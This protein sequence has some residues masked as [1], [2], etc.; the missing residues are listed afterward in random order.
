MTKDLTISIVTPSYNQGSF[1]ED[2]I[3]SV[4]NQDYPNIEHII[5]DAGST[6]N[7]I[8]I[9]KKYEGTYNMKWI[10]EPDRGQSDAINK[11]VK[12]AHGDIIG[13][14]NSDD[15][16][17]FTDSISRIMDSFNKNKTA[18]LVFGDLAFI[19]KEGEIMTVYAHQKFNYHKV[20][21]GRY[22]LG[23]QDVFFR[24]YVLRDNEL[25]TG[26]HFAMD[27]ELW[28]RIGNKYNF[29]HISEV[30]ACL[31]IYPET[32]SGAKSNVNKWIEEKENILSKFGTKENISLL[33][34]IFDKITRGGV[35]RMIGLFL[36]IKNKYIYKKNLAFKGS[37]KRFPYDIIQQLSLN[38]LSKYKS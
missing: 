5:I 38:P 14:L 37:Y 28:T 27:F 1:I 22:T 17:I 4:K 6:D 26:L 30:V 19:N 11:G 2:T 23:Q 24:N 9:L 21:N 29:K 15:V 20:I 10:S 35:S 25:R 18:D 7:T 33:E 16:Y 8:G 36:L 12:M 34:K 31:R 13:W 32:K 3:L